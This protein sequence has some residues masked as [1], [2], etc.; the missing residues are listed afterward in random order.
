ME[1]FGNRTSDQEADLPREKDRVLVGLASVAAR[2]C[3]LDVARVIATSFRER[4]DVIDLPICLELAAAIGAPPLL[5]PEN[6][7]EIGGRKFSDRA[8]LSSP[9]YLTRHAALLWVCGSPRRCAL[10][11]FR[12]LT[13]TVSRIAA[14]PLAMPALPLRSALPLT[15][16]APVAFTA[17][18]DAP[19]RWPTA[20][21]MPLRALGTQEQAELEMEQ[22]SG[23][24]SGNF[25]GKIFTGGQ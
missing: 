22:C 1:F 14:H 4:D 5:S 13:L 11:R 12:Q 23:N 8:A 10:P 19:T 7:V 2:A 18:L 21:L 16:G 3:E 9:P 20:R 15:M 6:E 24:F 25:F 17:T